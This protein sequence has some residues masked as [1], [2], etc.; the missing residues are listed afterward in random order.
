[1]ARQKKKIMLVN[2]WM[3]KSMEKASLNG[4]MGKDMK[5]NGIMANN[6]EKDVLYFLM[7]KEKKVFGKTEKG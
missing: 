2:I 1:M 6:M 7:E 5:V 4:G 3:I